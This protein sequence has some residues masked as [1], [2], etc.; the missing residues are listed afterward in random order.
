MQ[1][2]T[3]ACGDDACAE[4]WEAEIPPLWVPDCL[5]PVCACGALGWLIEVIQIVPATG[6]PFS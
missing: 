6:W 1:V 4:E 2:G 3:Y 5:L